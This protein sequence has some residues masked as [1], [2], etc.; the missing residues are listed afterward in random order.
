MVGVSDVGP[1][2]SR[3]QDSSLGI[4]RVP[5]LSARLLPVAIGVVTAR[6]SCLLHIDTIPARYRGSR[7]GNA[8]KEHRRRG[9]QIHGN[10]GNSLLSGTGRNAQLHARGR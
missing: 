5:V 7:G 10:P 1:F 2:G 4:A 9:E 8:S 3:R 6:T